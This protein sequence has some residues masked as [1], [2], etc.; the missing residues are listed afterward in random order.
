MLRLLP[1]LVVALLIGLPL[2]VAVRPARAEFAAIDQFVEARWRE[3]SSPGL[4]YAIVR[5]GAMVHARGIGSA[6]SA[7]PVT[8][9]TSFGIGSM[10]KSFTA[11]AVMQLVDAGMVELDAPVRRYLPAFRVADEAA[12][13]RIT[14]RQL[15]N[16][17]SGLPMY[18]AFWEP[19]SGTSGD[20]LEQRVRALATVQLHAEPG[21]T[22][23]YSNA[24]FDIA[25]L[26]VQTVSRQSFAAYVAEAI[27]TPLR[28][29][30]SFFPTGAERPDAVAQ[31]YQDWVGLAL[32]SDDVFGE[33]MWPTGGLH[34]SVNDMARYLAAQ[35]DAGR[36]SN[37]LLA[38]ESFAAL[39][40]A[41]GVGGSDYALGWDTAVI[42]GVPVVEHNG[43][44]PAF[45]SSMLFVPERGVGVVV[46]SNVA[47]VTLFGPL[48]SEQIANG[49]L[50]LLVGVEPTMSGFAGMRTALAV[51]L[52]L[53]AVTVWGLVSVPLEVRRI[54][55]RALSGTPL[56][57]LALSP[58]LSLSLGLFLLLGLPRLVGTP[59]W[60][61]WA[62]SP[63]VV[64]MLVIGS[65]LALLSAVLQ[66]A[67]LVRRARC[68]P[69]DPRPDGITA[70]AR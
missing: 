69:V 68:Q 1:L 60:S 23:Q 4:A 15:L 31:G 20:V 47:A 30:N 55:R 63:D 25:G 28:M 52:G 9:A 6:D 41:S 26:L 7:T 54:S 36:S 59:L 65:S 42:A 58:L 32:P 56:G 2:S 22:Y 45:H 39:H 53:L 21:T 35:L 40:R 19:P 8:P 3:T 61:L 13:E 12:S 46:L 67:V 24:N 16:Q 50:A 18:A 10:T 11:L 62:F 14:V 43:V 29:T 44:S 70:A 48:P 34:S 37:P 49:I 57:R 33:A 17:T 64:A 38:P 27:L 66:A 5:D 51:K